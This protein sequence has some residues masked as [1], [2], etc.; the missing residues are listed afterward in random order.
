[1]LVVSTDSGWRPV[2]L[3][4]PIRDF[5]KV[6]PKFTLSS[7]EERNRLLAS[8]G[9]LRMDN[10]I[11]PLR[12]PVVVGASLRALD[13]DNALD[14]DDD[15]FEGGSDNE[16]SEADEEPDEEVDEDESADDDDEDD[17]DDDED[18]D[19]EEPIKGN[20]AK[21]A[22]RATGRPKE[23]SEM[24]AISARSAVVHLVS[25]P[26]DS[27]LSAEIGSPASDHASQNKEPSDNR[28]KVSRERE[29]SPIPL[30]M[31]RPAICCGGGCS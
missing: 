12:R 7:S 4:S 11:R 22:D 16:D 8:G 5:R 25:T 13:K 3:L 10:S 6:I 23:R 30:N 21:E 19:E 20:G 1:M 17:D 9:S 26:I 24:S 2:Q 27:F 18:T 28:L 15:L 29:S 31:M 14:D